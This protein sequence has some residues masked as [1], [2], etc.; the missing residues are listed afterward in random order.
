MRGLGGVAW[1]QLF[2]SH[3][4]GSSSYTSHL[5]YG[6]PNILLVLR[7]NDPLSSWPL[8][9]RTQQGQYAVMSL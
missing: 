2:S 9:S 4:V 6:T 1:G 7:L 3:K 5:H 8:S